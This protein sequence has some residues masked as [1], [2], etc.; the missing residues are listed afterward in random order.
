MKNSICESIRVLASE[1]VELAYSPQCSLVVTD[2][3]WEL[4]QANEQKQLAI[5]QNILQP[6]VIF[7]PDG[8]PASAVYLKALSDTV[9]SSIESLQV[10][11]LVPVYR[12]EDL[13]AEERES[14][15]SISITDAVQRTLQFFPKQREFE[16]LMPDGQHVKY[17]IIP[18]KSFLSRHDYDAI[19]VV[20]PVEGQTITFYSFG[21]R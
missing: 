13:D 10:S 1:G 19:N 18:P 3:G 20:V 4:A 17:S 11:T 16:V 14:G 7:R 12:L 21:E 2:S 9:Q 15:I 8:K 6:I 5:A